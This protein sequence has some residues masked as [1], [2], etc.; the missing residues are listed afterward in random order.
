MDWRARLVPFT[1]GEHKSGDT[2]EAGDVPAEA[3]GIVS[4]LIDDFLAKSG[5]ASLKD[6]FLLH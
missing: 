3:A 1:F 2:S 5:T 4:K 6:Q